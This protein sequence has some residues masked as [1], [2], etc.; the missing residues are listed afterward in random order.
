MSYTLIEWVDAD[1][2]TLN[3]SSKYTIIKE[4]ITSPSTGLDPGLEYFVT[5]IPY[6]I[7][8]YD[9]RLVY[10]ESTKTMLDETDENGYRKWQI[11]Y[12]SVDRTDEEKQISIEEEEVIQNTTILPTSK[13]IKYLLI[14]IALVRRES[15]GLTMTD[16]MTSFMDDVDAKALKVW[17]NNITAS[18]KIKCLESGDEICIDEDWENEDS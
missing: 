14:Y 3:D 8:E 10:I 1:D 5:D 18:A 9:T 12:A 7:P 11:T 13:Q 2:Q 4:N 17:Q 16:T 15:L 6:D